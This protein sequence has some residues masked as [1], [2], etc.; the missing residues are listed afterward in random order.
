[1]VNETW[2]C[3]ADVLAMKALRA[4][5]LAASIGTGLIA[6]VCCGGSLVLASIGLGG[7]YGALALWKLVPQVLATGA[8]SIVTVNYLF[9]RRHAERLQ[10][11]RVGDPGRLRQGML[12]S[13]TVGIAGMAGSFLFLE[14]LNHAVVNGRVFLTH[15]DYA[16][17]I[18]PGVPNV[19]LLYAAASFAALGL[20]RALPFPGD[21]SSRRD[22]PAA[23]RQAVLRV[24]LFVS[25]AAVL[26]LLWEVV[27]DW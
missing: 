14:W 26:V 22:G 18:I 23:R 16:Q 8:L 21:V 12:L 3:E 20:L 13:A 7:L 5:P 6:S 2:I 9:Y 4:R 24:G 11:A 27:W 1:M 19:R 15:P 17:S 10:R 25:G